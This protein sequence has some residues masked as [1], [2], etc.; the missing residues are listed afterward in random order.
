MLALVAAAALTLVAWWL[1]P[2]GEPRR[3][4]VVGYP[5][6]AAYNF[7]GMFLG[8]RLSVWLLPLLTAT[9]FV[10]LGRTAA[11]AGTPPQSAAAPVPAPGT[12]PEQAGL[13][14]THLPTLPAAGVVA[15][16]VSSA[17]TDPHAHLTPLGV[18]AAVAYVVVVLLVTRL[19]SRRLADP[20]AVVNTLAATLAAIG[21]IFWFTQHTAAVSPESADS[22]PWLPFWYAA[23]AIVLAIA[24][25]ARRRTTGT[26]PR[27]LQGRVNRVLVGAVA[28]F[29][30]TASLP[31]SIPRLTGFD[32]MMS[33]AGADLWL[34]GDFPWRDV[35]FIHGFFDDALRSA[36]GFG[37]FEHTVWGADAASTALWVPLGWTGLYLLGVWTAPRSWLAPLGVLA[38]VA[39]LASS[40]P[41]P[42]R[43]VFAAPV[44]VLLGEAI[45]R[46][47]EKSQSRWT[48]LLTVT[49]FV[50][51]VLVPEASFQVLATAAVLVL[52]D[53]VHRSPSASW[54]RNLR[55]TRDFV[56]TG[57]VCTCLW[58]AFLAL[59][60]SLTAF[61]DYYLVFGPGHVATGAQPMLRLSSPGWLVSFLLASALV[62]VPQALACRHLF[63]RR[64]TT[65]EHWVLVATTLF[66]ALYGEKALGR[67]DP[68][69]LAQ[70]VSMTLPLVIV[71]LALLL[72]GLERRLRRSATGHPSRGARSALLA[73]VVAS[74]LVL[75]FAG[76]SAPDNNKSVVSG[77]STQLI[78][79]SGD[80]TVDTEMLEDLKAVVDGLAGPHGL[81]FDFTNSPGY[82]SYL[83]QRDSPTAFYHVSMAVPEFSQDLVVDALEARRPAVVA[84]D[85][86]YIGLPL[87]DLVAND[88]RHYAIARYL[89]NGWTPVVRSHDVLFLVRNDLVAGLPSL[90][91]L[92]EPAQTNGLY[93][94]GRRCDWGYTPG[95]LESLPTGRSTTLAVDTPR[96]ARWLDVSGWAYDRA[97]A[98][99]VRRILVAVGDRVVQTLHADQWRRDLAFLHADRGRQRSSFTGW[100]ATTE[101]G[102]P[103]VY[104]VLSDGA[105]HP[106]GGHSSHG[107]PGSLHLSGRTIPTSPVPSGDG[108]VT[109]E[110][111]AAQV[112]SVDVPASVDLTG[113]AL[114]RFRTSGNIGRS[115][116]LL[117]ESLR[118]SAS[119]DT[120]I[121]FRT[122]PWQG[123]ST[124]VRVGSCPQW[125]G[126][127]TKQLFLVQ[128]GGRPITGIRISD[129]R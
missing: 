69:H 63:T 74:S 38:V 8:Y 59:N 127:D 34:R 57:L 117:A 89:L 1:L 44:F 111:R 39:L 45:R 61:V 110:S 120:A 108:E 18:A 70:S 62:A 72:Q 54:W 16:A 121:T 46:G 118:G 55:L 98:Q 92:H 48:V 99:P 126:Y 106:I 65:A 122:R 56:L 91:T 88:V 5:S 37:L 15:I 28:A 30:L 47:L 107:R 67:A 87:W 29:M 119:R 58:A 66:A 9:I 93:F 79:Y 19:G 64:A 3:L 78:G 116:V 53:L 2:T 22:W 81:L 112:S 76:W 13:L 40:V 20:I 71:L 35:L 114:A 97:A 100:I 128:S 50:E 52:A 4:D 23:P 94:A 32:D 95:Y 10:L 80:D 125:H 49:L 129:V 101:A 102:R 33:T 109:L 103:Q 84:F 115:E 6:F 17:S 124:S 21:G 77:R 113:S 7:R 36:A 24:W 73:V 105:A 51:A 68:A 41:F 11:F 123:A 12:S 27:D 75:A 104:A 82:V 86:T 26:P 25:L 42:M 83:L 31:S 90:P 96:N 14:S 43:W 85:S 60:S